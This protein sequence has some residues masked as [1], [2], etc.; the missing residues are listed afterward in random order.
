VFITPLVIPFNGIPHTQ[1]VEMGRRIG[2]GQFNESDEKG[3][4]ERERERETDRP[5]GFYR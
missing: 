3:E 1:R 2:E 5:G 4:K